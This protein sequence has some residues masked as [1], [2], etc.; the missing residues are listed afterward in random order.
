MFGLL[1][2]AMMSLAIASS[3]KI[4]QFIFANQW[5]F[6]AVMITE[7]VVVFGLSAA[8]KR[9]S[10]TTATLGFL[11]YSVLDG[12][13]FSVIFLAYQLGSIGQ[14][15]LLAAGMFGGLAIYGSVTKEVSL[16]SEPLCRWD[17]SASSF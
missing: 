1:L 5:V 3:E 13:T 9:L 10:A 8:H 4:I 7:L 6:Y 11:F 2:T 12:V 16:A 14:I 17:S 15:F